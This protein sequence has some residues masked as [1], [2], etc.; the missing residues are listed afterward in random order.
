MKKT[1]GM[2]AILVLVIVSTAGASRPEPQGLQPGDPIR[3]HIKPLPEDVSRVMLTSATDGRRQFELVHIDGTVEQLSSEAFAQRLYT[4]QAGKPWFYRLLN[5]TSPI[6]FAWVFLG[7]LGQVLFTGRMILQ[8]LTSEKAKRSVVPVGFWWMSL[9]GASMLLIYFIWR[10]DIV[11]VL[12]Q[13]TGWLI[14]VRN[15]W[16]IYR[17]SSDELARAAA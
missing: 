3:I 2:T 10:R 9:A 4:S 14:Y 1:I 5:I 12:G 6:G 7:L 11:G 8:W 16:F 15:L 13:A 17:N